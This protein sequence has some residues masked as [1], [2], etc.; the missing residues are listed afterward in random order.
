MEFLP[1][2]LA[3]A[4]E[5]KRKGGEYFSLEQVVDIAY[6]LAG[7]LAELQES[8]IAHGNI[9][10]ASVFVADDWVFR[11]SEFGN[12]TNTIG[13]AVH[14]KESVCQCKP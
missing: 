11:L 12:S 8:S 4:I 5:W 10:A 14:A 6:T 1:Q 7:A 3:Q 2:S 9:R 13:L